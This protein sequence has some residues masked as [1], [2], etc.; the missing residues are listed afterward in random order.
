MARTGHTGHPTKTASWRMRRELTVALARESDWTPDE[1]SKL[2]D[3]MRTEVAKIDRQLP[4]SYQV[5]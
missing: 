1:D 4:R 5:G 2:A 3:V